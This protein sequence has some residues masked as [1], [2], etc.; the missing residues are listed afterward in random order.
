[1][2]SIS[3]CL[4]VLFERGR[5]RGLE[6]TCIKPPFQT[7]FFFIGNSSNKKRIIMDLNGGLILQQAMFDYH[8]GYG[9]G[10]CW[11]KTELTPRRSLDENLGVAMGEMT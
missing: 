8:V 10:S 9:M 6:G 2:I 11:L 4:D 7:G 3:Y 5:S 1:M